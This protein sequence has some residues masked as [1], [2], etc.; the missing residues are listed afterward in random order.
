MSIEKC[1]C[2]KAAA[3][4]TLHLICIHK[5]KQKIMDYAINKKNN[6]LI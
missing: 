5:I 1:Q 4:A 6:F 2:H 3:L